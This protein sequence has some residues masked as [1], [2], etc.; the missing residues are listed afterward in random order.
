[1]ATFGRQATDRR[2]QELSKLAV[3]VREPPRTLAGI[4]LTPEAY[5]EVVTRSTQAP[6][7]PGGLNLEGYLRA[8]TSSEMWKQMEATPDHGVIVHTQLV[9]AVIDAAYNAARTPTCRPILTSS[10]RCF[11]TRWR[12]RR[13]CN[14]NNQNSGAQGCALVGGLRSSRTFCPSDRS[15][16]FAQGFVVLAKQVA[17]IHGKL[18]G[19][20]R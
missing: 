10:R 19:A 8:L 6:I 7:F 3:N 20:L 13:I 4:T 1:M 5:D 16:C 11:S 17:V 14:L 15:C 9:Q 2:D 18:G 12:R